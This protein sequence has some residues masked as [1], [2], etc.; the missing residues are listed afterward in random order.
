M[1]MH[2]QIELPWKTAGEKS[3]EQREVRR[4]KPTY[5]LE[6]EIEAECFIHPGS[7]VQERLNG[8]F[9]VC[10]HIPIFW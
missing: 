9:L 2:K 6:T 1:P 4:A 7:A 3:S 5:V 10:I 8:R